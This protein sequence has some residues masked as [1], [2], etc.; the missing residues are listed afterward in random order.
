MSHRVRPAVWIAITMAAHWPAWRWAWSTACHG[1]D[2]SLHALAALAALW[3]VVVGVARA[4]RCVSPDL[5]GPALALALSSLW[6][7]SL[8][9]LA[10]AGGAVATTTWVISRVCGA[11]RIHLGGFG[12]GLLALPILPVFELIVGPALRVPVASGSAWLLR[13]VGVPVESRGSVLIHPGGEVWVDPPCAGLAMLWTGAI[14]A[15][16][17]ASACRLS[18]LQTLLVGAV[19]ALSVAIGNVWRVT[20]LFILESDPRPKPEW[21]HTGVGLV[22][23]ALILLAIFAVVQGHCPV[24]RAPCSASAHS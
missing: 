17:A 8:G 3:L 12:L 13:L 10:G 6:A 21:V 22:V 14:A 20:S 2:T 7:P 15:C 16:A 11:Q 9:P 24:R 5:R 23:E 19:A 1:G 18:N 4:P